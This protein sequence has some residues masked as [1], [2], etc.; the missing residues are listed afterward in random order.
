LGALSQ[1]L[2]SPG[3]ETMVAEAL[4]AAE[5]LSDHVMRAQALLAFWHDLTDEQRSAVADSV[6]GQ[7]ATSGSRGRDLLQSFVQLM[8]PESAGTIAAEIYGNKDLSVQAAGFSAVARELAEPHRSSLVGTASQIARS[9]PD[10]AMRSAA[11]SD[12]ADVLIKT[13]QFGEAL[14]LINAIE[15]E[16]VRNYM[17]GLASEALALAGHYEQACDTA[18]QLLDA[19]ARTD[20]AMGL[21]LGSRVLRRLTEQVPDVERA[22]IAARLRDVAATVSGDATTVPSLAEAAEALRPGDRAAAQQLLN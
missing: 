17:L 3:R 10:P 22:A 4:A 9:L 2:P 12:V 11:Q 19:T 8:P 6:I 13:G 7:L 15:D 5:G 16:Q 1:R 20:P 18:E 14:E 21:S